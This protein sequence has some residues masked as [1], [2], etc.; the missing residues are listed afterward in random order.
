MAEVLITLADTDDDKVDINCN[1]DIEMANGIS[2]ANTH[3]Q[4]HAQLGLLTIIAN[5]AAGLGVHV[6]K[7]QRARVTITLADTDNGVDI[8]CSSDIDM[9][10][11]CVER[12]HQGTKLSGR[13]HVNH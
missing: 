5:T 4:N 1:S 10:R 3:A 8:S 12:K 11:G 9:I 13:C 6:N 2:N 7:A